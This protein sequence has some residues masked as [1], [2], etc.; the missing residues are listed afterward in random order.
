M[1]YK[2]SLSLIFCFSPFPLSRW[3]C[4][5][6]PSKREY[7][8]ITRRE[9][10]HLPT[11]PPQLLPTPEVRDYLTSRQIY[12]AAENTERILCACLENRVRQRSRFLVLTIRIAATG[13]KNDPK[14]IVASV[15]GTVTLYPCLVVWGTG[16]A[17][18][19]NV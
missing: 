10:P 15:R 3:C 13:D 12:L 4:C 6:I 2:F 19:S 1:N 17:S 14:R 16:F 18:T 8:Y 11:L 9:T 5:L 7:I